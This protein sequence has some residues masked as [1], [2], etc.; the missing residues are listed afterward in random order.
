MALFE[1]LPHQLVLIVHDRDFVV[2]CR[3]Y[4]E[5][6]EIPSIKVPEGHCGLPKECD[7]SRVSKPGMFGGAIDDLVYK[8]LP[9]KALQ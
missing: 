5:D 3:R 1:V 7:C 2:G 8:P 6:G 4:Y 9:R